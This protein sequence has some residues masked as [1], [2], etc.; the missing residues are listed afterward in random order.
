MMSNAPG[1]IRNLNPAE[2]AAAKARFLAGETATAVQPVTAPAIPSG[3]TSSTAQAP[4]PNPMVIPHARDMSPEEYRT[5][6]NIF[7]SGG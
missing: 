3:S 7:K 6:R 4:N 5:A 1:S 2:Y